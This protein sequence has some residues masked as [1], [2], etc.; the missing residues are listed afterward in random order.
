VAHTTQWIG[1]AGVL[2][3]GVCAVALVVAVAATSATIGSTAAD[4]SSTALKS[5]SVPNF[6][7]ILANS[8]GRT[9][10][11]LS[12]ESGAKVHCTGTCLTKWVPD[13]VAKAVTH[14]SVGTGV[15]GVISFVTRSSTKKQVTYNSFPLYTD[16]SDTGAAQEHGEAVVADGGT[17]YMVHA[18]AT[19]KGAT[20]VKPLLQK[21]NAGGYD[22]VLANAAS[23]SLYV[24]SNESAGAVHCTGGCLTTWPPLL[25]TSATSSI[26]LGAGVSGK[27]GFVTRSS[28]TKQVTF[29]GYPVY[30]YSGDT[31]ANQTNGEGIAADGGTWT[32]AD[33]GAKTTAG[34]PVAP[35]SG[36]GWTKRP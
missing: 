2:R 17:W 33:A 20:E 4:A 34:T 3:R 36:G 24:L 32:L 23:R 30:T 8:S 11:V 5:V 12:T 7:D 9:L 29:N 35:S 25:V 21:A 22:G 14:V 18:T 26:A 10:Y 19:T 15:K 28:T 1:R 27:I 13:L 31:G 16:A 6:S